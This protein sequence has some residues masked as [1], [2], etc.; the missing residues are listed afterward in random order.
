DIA[1]MFFAF[2]QEFWSS[3]SAF[4][5]PFGVVLIILW[6]V[7]QLKQGQGA[8]QS[9]PRQRAPAKPTGPECPYCAGPI[10]RGVVKC[11]HCAS[12]IK[13]CGFKGSSYP[14]KAD[15]DP[16]VAINE[17]LRKEKEKQGSAKT[18][19]RLCGAEIL[20]VTANYY[21]GRCAPCGK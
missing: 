8:Q 18:R 9:Q 19:C 20:V 1:V 11:R 15:A 13:W 14:M 17:L 12:D 3:P 4:G 16:N 7:S 10:T 5:L 6:V 21:D 2:S